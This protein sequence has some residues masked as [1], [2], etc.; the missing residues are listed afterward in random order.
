[1]SVATLTSFTNEEYCRLDI[2]TAAQSRRPLQYPP[3]AAAWKASPQDLPDYE[4]NPDMKRTLTAFLWLALIAP[5]LL[6]LLHFSVTIEGAT[7]KL[8]W[9]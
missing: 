9:T 7:R 6:V 3:Q 1:S 5:L 2:T 4:H 8:Q